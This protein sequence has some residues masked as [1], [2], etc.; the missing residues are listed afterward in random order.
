V[1][2][3]ALPLAHR[4]VVILADLEGLSYKEI[5]QVVECSI[6]TVMSM[7]GPFADS[8]VARA[9]ACDPEKAA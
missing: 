7:F 3:K 8:P 6:G 2:L 9:L 4:E 1:P 5:A